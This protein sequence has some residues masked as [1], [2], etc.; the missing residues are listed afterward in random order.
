M[1]IINQRNSPIQEFRTISSLVTF[2]GERFRDK[3]MTLKKKEKILIF[4]KC[5]CFKS[6]HLADEEFIY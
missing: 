1:T 2:T 6:I 3:D 5:F 4:L